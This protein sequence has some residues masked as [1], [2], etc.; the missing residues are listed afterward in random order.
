M[1]ATSAPTI[2][3]LQ[4]AD[5]PA[6]WAALGFDVHDRVC[7]IATVRLRFTDPSAGRHAQGIVGWSLRELVG[8]ELDGLPTTMSQRPVPVPARPHPNG[9][10]AIDHVVAASPDLDR[11]VA[12][13]QAAGLDL[14]RVREQP[15]PAGAPRQAF[16]RLGQEILEVI[17][18]PAEVLASSP[19]GER[20]GGRDRPARFW[21]LALLVADL[22]ATVATLGEHAGEARA[23]VQPGRRIASVRRSA[24]LAVPLAL[25]SADER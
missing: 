9:V 13:L 15:T 3:E 14:R 10:L 6:R 19:Q 11:S 12:A 18:E 24:G 23:A 17:Q 7:Q 16:F 1:N 20:A 22:D 8:S 2:D 4:L 5:D 25:M 21:G